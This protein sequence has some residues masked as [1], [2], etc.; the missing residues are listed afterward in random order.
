MIYSVE[1]PLYT[2]SN[3]KTWARDNLGVFRA[4]VEYAKCFRRIW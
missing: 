1:E 4:H 3:R 2:L